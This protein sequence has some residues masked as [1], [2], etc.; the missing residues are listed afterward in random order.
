MHSVPEKLKVGPVDR[1]QALALGVSRDVL[2]GVQFRR[3][4]QGVYCHR[5]RAMTWEDEVRAAQLALPKSACTTGATRLQQ[6]GFDVGPRLPLHFV[7]EGDLHRDLDGVFLHRTVKMPPHEGTAVSDEAAYVAFCAE[8]RMIDAIKVGCAMLRFGRLDLHLL[9]EILGLEKWRRGV[10]E[11]QHVLPFLDGRCRSMPE[12]ELMAYILVAGLPI[13]DI[14][15]EL[16]VA[17][18]VPLT[19]DMWF[20]MYTLAIEYEGSQHQEDRSQY[21]SDIDRYST[22]RRHGVAYELVTKEHLRSPKSTVRLVH[23]AL[24][25]RGY[26][27]PAPDFGCQWDSLFRSLTDVVRPPRAA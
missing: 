24:A 10:P 2:E 1:Q 18:G 7:I 19:P 23:G 3:I 12:A 27:G 4:H 16:E 11:T 8:A 9:D 17:P 5:E 14:N 6:L 22:Y 13:P 20:E 25:G 15:R 21:T 26:E